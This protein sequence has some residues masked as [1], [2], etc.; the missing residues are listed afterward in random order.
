M[1]GS[2]ASRTRKP[3]LPHQ[4]SRQ[5]PRVRKSRSNPEH[6][7]S[8]RLAPPARSPGTSSSSSRTVP[9][10]QGAPLPEGCGP[11][12][13]PPVVS[14]VEFPVQ[15]QVP[16]SFAAWGLCCSPRRLGD[17]CRPGQRSQSPPPGGRSGDRRDILSVGG[18]TTRAQSSPAGT[19][20]APSRGFFIL[21][22]AHLG[23]ATMSPFQVRKLRL[24]EGQQC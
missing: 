24:R 3:R 7:P 17:L 5:R 10:P 19:H 13:R 15:P 4:P 14:E 11:G 2:P 9:T 6:L 18:M 1:P 8:R 23:S 20:Q 16:R 12:R 22:Q 21:F